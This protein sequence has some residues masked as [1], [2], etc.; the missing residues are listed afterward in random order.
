MKC[1]ALK[2]QASVGVSALKNAGSRQQRAVVLGLGDDDHAVLDTVECYEARE[3]LAAVSF[4]G[5][6]SIID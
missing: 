5:S 2:Y 4:V 6:H 3:K 1:L